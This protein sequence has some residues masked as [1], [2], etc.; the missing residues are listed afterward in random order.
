MIFRGTGCGQRRVLMACLAGTRTTA[1]PSSTT[2]SS[3][4]GLVVRAAARSRATDRRSTGLSRTTRSLL[5]TSRLAGVS[6]SLMQPEATRQYESPNTPPYATGGG[7][8]GSDL[9]TSYATITFNSAA[10]LLGVVNLT[11]IPFKGGNLSTCGVG[12]VR[13]ALGSRPVPYSSI[14]IS[15]RR[16]RPRKIGGLQVGQPRRSAAASTFR[17]HKGPLSIWPTS[18][19]ALIPSASRASAGSISVRCRPR[20]GKRRGR[21]RVAGFGCLIK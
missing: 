1:G 21:C 13:C 4:L 3:A 9:P 7:T 6:N 16:S 15:A 11:A 19:P 8:N 12:N 10:G 2:R 20:Q 14:P 5:I 18:R 17:I